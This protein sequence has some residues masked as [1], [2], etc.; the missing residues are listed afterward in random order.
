M[1]DIAK[2]LGQIRA[3]KQEIKTALKR[4]GRPMQ[5]VPFAQYPNEIMNISHILIGINGAYELDA[6][7][8]EVI[9]QGDLVKIYQLQKLGILKHSYAFG[10]SLRDFDTA[11]ENDELY[12]RIASTVGYA[13]NRFTGEFLYTFNFGSIPR[14]NLISH[15][16]YLYTC[17][18]P[19]YL[20]KLDKTTG[21]WNQQVNLGSNFSRGK[22]AIKEGRLYVIQNDRI[23]IRN[24]DTLVNI[25]Q[26]PFTVPGQFYDALMDN[27]LVYVLYEQEG[28][29]RTMVYNLNTLDVIYETLPIPVYGSARVE[30]AIF[31]DEDYL[32]EVIKST[33]NN[34]IR[35]INLQTFE[36]EQIKQ[37]PNEISNAVMVHEYIYV[38]VRQDT[39][40]K[41]HIINKGTLNLAF[42]LI[43]DVY[44]SDSD[45]HI[46]AADDSQLYIISGYPQ[47]LDHLGA[48]YNIFRGNNLPVYK[49]NNNNMLNSFDAFAV[50][51]A[52]ETGSKGDIRKVKI[53]MQR[54]DDPIGQ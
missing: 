11:Y 40:K 53:I 1:E 18:D 48:I 24:L 34:C 2:K 20:R 4:K 6:Q 26:F 42:E 44:V 10:I 47:G 9:E 23:S 32:Y 14:S 21:I 45:L 33:D 31:L 12:I 37:L 41:V 17:V 27:N 22:L 5:N 25:E 3:I 8:E 36:I 43:P 13:F 54:G 50:G 28:M 51:V 46:L 15:G 38:G 29:A 19:Q 16:N 39:D 35:K 7:Y 52:Q 49:I 30:S